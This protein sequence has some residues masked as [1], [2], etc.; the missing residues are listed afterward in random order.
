MQLDITFQ[1]GGLQTSVENEVTAER[2]AR[3][4]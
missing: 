3:V 1:Y 2:I 4:L